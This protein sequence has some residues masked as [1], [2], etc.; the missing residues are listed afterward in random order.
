[1]TMSKRI[2]IIAMA[3]MALG[4]TKMDAQHTQRENFGQGWYFV[5]DDDHDSMMF[6]WE[7][8][9]KAVEYPPQVNLPHDWGVEGDFDINYPGETGKL[10]W[11]GYAR[12]WKV[13]YL[14]D[15]DLDG[16]N[17]FLEVDGAMSNPKVF[18]N[19]SL[20][21]R[22]A[23]G[24]SSFNVDLTPYVRKGMNVITIELDNP[25]ESS[26]WY[27][28]GGI[29][30]NVWLTKTPP[31]GIAQWGTFVYS[32]NITPDKCGHD[33]HHNSS[34]RDRQ[35][36]QGKAHNGGAKGRPDYLLRSYGHRRGGRWIRG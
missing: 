12:Y 8:G 25:N 5:Q 11:W 4:G 7:K 35:S 24:Y 19:D 1:M 31:V 17:F 27:P 36:A 30:R 21:G 22:W 15:D 14:Y 32:E 9:A 18:C 10:H 3:I 20:A 33:G 13:F 2:F 34:R 28:G 26:R 29:Y 6:K 16:S 23:Y